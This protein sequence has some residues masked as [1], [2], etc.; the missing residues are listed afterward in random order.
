MFTKS[1]R[2]FVMDILVPPTFGANLVSAPL[3]N[4]LTSSNGI[5]SKAELFEE[6]V[7]ATVSTY[8]LLLGCYFE[9]VLEL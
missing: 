5:I 3:N 6:T 7:A 2:G 8:N 1:L 4:V 9:L